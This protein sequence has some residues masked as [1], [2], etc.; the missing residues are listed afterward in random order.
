MEKGRHKEIDMYL[1]NEYV[2]HYRVS[3]EEILGFSFKI[4][5]LY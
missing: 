4:W 3:N 1:D 2:E 5:A